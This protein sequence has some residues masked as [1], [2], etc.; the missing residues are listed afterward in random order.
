MS[1]QSGQDERTAGGEANLPGIDD[2]EI[3]NPGELARKVVEE[4]E[5]PRSS[6]EEGAGSDSSA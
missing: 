6:T 3:A 5:A 4:E 1:E 2:E